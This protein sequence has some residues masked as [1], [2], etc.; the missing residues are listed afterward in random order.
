MTEPVEISSEATEPAPDLKLLALASD[1]DRFEGYSEPH[2]A[3]VAEIAESIGQKFNLASHDSFIM[4]QA[5]LGHDIGELAMNR[6]YI[7]QNRTL[8][9]AESLDMRRHPVIGEQQAAKKGLSRGAQLLIRW[10]HEAWNGGG[11]P[12]GLEET[13]IPLAARI[14][15]VADAFASL[16]ADRPFRSAL[17]ESD[18]KKALIELA[19]I[20]FDPAV[21]KAFLE[22]A[23]SG[24]FRS[25]EASASGV[26]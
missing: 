25:K 3:R 26:E 20:K 23:D 16:T 17:S 12:D 2:A 21:V 11:Y 6:E 8:S 15:S 14:L 5:A 4:R 19:G 9:A 10:H 24:L 18:A 1:I 22:I 7:R 13:Q